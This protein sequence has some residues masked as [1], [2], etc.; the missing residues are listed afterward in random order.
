MYILASFQYAY[1]V[2][3]KRNGA[4][5]Q[6]WG[7]SFHTKSLEYLSHLRLY[8]VSF[9]ILHLCMDMIADIF[10]HLYL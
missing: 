4:M 10:P 2:T 5:Y 7:F 6:F 9:L 3:L 8:K 1:P